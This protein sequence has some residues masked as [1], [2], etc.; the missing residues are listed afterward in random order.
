MGSPQRIWLLAGEASG[1]A[2]GSALIKALRYQ[3]PDLEFFGV[4]GPLMEQAGL[5]TSL[6]PLRDLA[7]MGLVEI[8]PKIRHLSQRLQE[9]ASDIAEKKP[10]MVITID[11]PG[12]SLR[13]L[14]K[15]MPLHI[16]R[17]HYVAP[18]VWAWRENRVKKFPGLWEELLCLL[19]FE[20]DYFKKHNVPV[21]FVGH[22]IVN[23][24][25]DKGNAQRFRALYNIAENT[26]ILIL[27]PGSRRS[28]APR[29]L[30]VFQEMVARLHN[31]FP[32]M[33]VVIP[34]SSIMATHIQHK[35]SQWVIPPLII[36]DHQEKYDA[37]AAAGAALT[38]SGTST[39]ELALAG[40]PMAVT[41][42]VNPLTAI[43]ARRLI[44]V[45]YVAMINLLAQDYIVPELLQENCQPKILADTVYSLLTDRKKAETQ[46][47]AFKTILQTLKPAHTLSPSDAA[48]NEVLALLDSTA[49][50]SNNKAL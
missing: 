12:F 8:L 17:I 34:S 22:P 26:P 20:E 35:T 6:F 23:Y 39:L 2:L 3:R 42:R 11:S 7:V 49:R 10:D 14:K 40:V 15:I 24:G 30:P 33:K 31:H 50:H 37:F 19:P 18:Q 1:D 46:R 44:K 47:K 41:Y 28:E 9:A 43:L 29:L 48:A 4:G 5:G 32:D 13:L 16:P 25:A 21:R 38:K 27:M 45:P 36:L